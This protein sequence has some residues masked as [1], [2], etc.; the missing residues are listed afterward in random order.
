LGDRR[1]RL[2][3]GDVKW[4]IDANPLFA[5]GFQAPAFSWSC[6]AQ[7]GAPQRRRN[8]AADSNSAAETPRPA[9]AW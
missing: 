6:V 1:V 2:E 9:S 5:P 8:S 4:R 7:D 3:A